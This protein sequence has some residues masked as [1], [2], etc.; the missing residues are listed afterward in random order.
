MSVFSRDVRDTV[1]A[2]WR[3]VAAFVQI[4]F[5]L[6]FYRSSSVLD[7]AVRP[8]EYKFFKFL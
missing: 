2:E 3:H 5:R 7:P 8:A 1:S 6:Y 4:V